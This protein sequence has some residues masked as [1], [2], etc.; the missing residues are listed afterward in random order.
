MK[1]MMDEFMEK[2]SSQHTPVRI[3][4]CVIGS[5]NVGGI[6]T[7]LMELYR[8]IDRTKYQFDF[9]VH[10]PKENYYEK[11]IN[12]LGGRLYRVPF[13][14]QA[15]LEH[16][17]AFRK[18]LEDHEEYQIVHIHT[19]YSIMYI[20]AKIAKKLGRIVI[21]HSHNSSASKK[22]S[23]FHQLY[24]KRF[25]KTADYRLTCSNIAAEWMYM[26]EDMETVEIWKNAIE[27]KKFQYHEEKRKEIRQAYGVMDKFILG[28]VGRLS[29][30]KNQS[31]LLD[32]FHNVLCQ[33]P[34]AEL[35][36]V[37]DGEDREQLEKKVRDMKLDQSVRFW[38]RQSNVSDYLMAFDVFVLT[39][40]W[41]G[42][43]VVLMEAQAAGLPVVVPSCTDEMAHITEH[44]EIIENYDDIAEW[45]HKIVKYQGKKIDRRVQN[46]MVAKAGFDMDTQVKAAEEFYDRV[47]LQEELG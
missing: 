6:E 38:G 2:K 21:I 44:V 26:P 8:N 1:S 29:Y 4:Q 14:S 24:K 31:F 12:Q 15:P 37:G 7:M 18:L 28:C 3:L 42:L 33:C 25:S 9:V 13:Y 41:E 47:R 34:N 46:E 20:D 32:I 17:R 16:K 23:L 30:Q 11:E 5:M 27:V 45:T 36:L 22:R 10:D 19:T 43:G 39:S 35:W 40:R